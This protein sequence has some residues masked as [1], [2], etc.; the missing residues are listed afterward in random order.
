MHASC[1][2]ADGADD[3]AKGTSLLEVYALE[4]QLCTATRDARRMKAIYPKTLNLNAAVAD[5]RIMGVI[6][7]E[8][9]KMYMGDGAWDAA[10]NEFYEG[11]RAY[12]EA[13]NA[14]AKDCLKYVV[15]AN[16]LASSDINPFDSREA[17]VYKDEPE[18]TAMIELRSAYELKDVGA[19]E[20]LLREPRN[21]IVT[22]PLIMQYVEPLLRNIRALVLIRLVQPY[23]RIRL[24]FIA[25]EINVPEE[26]VEAMVLDQVLHL[27]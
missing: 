14:R 23:Q 25:G 8:G 3:P 11:F 15:L 17:K 19:F 7:E 5:P 20:K 6:R 13:G 12:Q 9:G 22:D 27:F 26:E 4:I 1:V 24:S 2:T 18:I 16:M 10:Y 21:R